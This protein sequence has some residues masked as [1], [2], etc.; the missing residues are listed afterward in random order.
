MTTKLCFVRGA[1]WRDDTE[2]T[3]VIEVDKKKVALGGLTELAVW[4]Q[5]IMCRLGTDTS[6]E[7][8]KVSVLWG[9]KSTANE[10]ENFWFRSESSA[11]LPATRS[12]LP[13]KP[14]SEGKKLSHRFFRV[15]INSLV[16]NKQRSGALFT[17]I[18]DNELPLVEVNVHNFCRL[19]NVYKHHEKC[20]ESNWIDITEWCVSAAGFD[21]K[22][23]GGD[24]HSKTNKPTAKINIYLVSI[25]YGF[26]NTPSLRSLAFLL[27][28]FT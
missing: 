23:W 5:S 7:G 10:I 21:G 22:E 19:R 13:A 12:E 9:Q 17:I 28:T 14:F 1:E 4:S 25:S 24:S 8:I 15:A 6:R 2:I 16:I 18:D 3:M 27:K 26:P 20:F 11:S